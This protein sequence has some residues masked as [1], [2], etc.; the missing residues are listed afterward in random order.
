MKRLLLTAGIL[1]ASLLAFVGCDTNLGINTVRGSG[2]INAHTINATD[3]TGLNISGAYEVT[4]RQADHFTVILEIQDNLMNYVEASV[5]NGV[6][7]VS[8]SR[9]FSTTWDNTPHLRVYAPYLDNLRTS[10]AVDA[11]L[12]LDVDTL[13]INTSGAADVRLEGSANTLEIRTSGAS[14][15]EAFYFIASDVTV[16]VSGAGEVE[17]HATNTLDAR[18]TGAGRVTYDGNPSVSRSVSGAG[19]IRSRH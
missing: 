11:Y 1:A 15:I 16:S 14:N 9:N 8:G 19:I 4:F 3:F 13:E 2:A 10:G 18:I 12:H 6:L 17:V 7:H 5:I